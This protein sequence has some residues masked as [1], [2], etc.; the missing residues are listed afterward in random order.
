MTYYNKFRITREWAAVIRAFL[1]LRS[2][3]FSFGSLTYRCRPQIPSS[4]IQFCKTGRRKPSCPF[5]FRNADGNE[6]DYWKLKLE[7]LKGKTPYKN[8]FLREWNWIKY[9]N[10]I[11]LS[12][13][14]LLSRPSH[15]WKALRALSWFHDVFELRLLN[16]E[17]FFTENSFKSKLKILGEFRCSLEI[18]WRH[19]VLSIFCHWKFNKITKNSFEMKNLWGCNQFT[20]GPTAQSRLVY[21]Y[22]TDSLLRGVQFPASHEAGPISN[23]KGGHLQDCWKTIGSV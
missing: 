4:D 12:W 10:V 22:V 6:L 9:N 17:Y 21:H 2:C 8:Q 1:Q 5:R 20:L 18:C 11:C 23:V 7:V 14:D 13:W 15:C 16:I 3:T 19:W